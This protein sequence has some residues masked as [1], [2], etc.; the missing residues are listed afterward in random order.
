LKKFGLK[1]AGT[2]TGIL[3]SSSVVGYFAG[4][5]SVG[6]MYDSYHT[7]VPG[8]LLIGLLVLVGAVINFFVTSESSLEKETVV[9]PEMQT[10]PELTN[11]NI[12]DDKL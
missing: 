1:N 8:T 4:A 7:Y 3:W 6:Y 10:E 11:V 5:P 2:A 9:E 12:L